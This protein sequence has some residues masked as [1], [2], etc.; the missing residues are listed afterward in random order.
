MSVL[1]GLVLPCYGQLRYGGVANGQDRG[2]WSVKH[3]RGQMRWSRPR[4]GLIANRGVIMFSW[5]NWT[6]IFPGKMGLSW[7]R[8]SW[9]GAG[10]R[11]AAEAEAT[12]FC[13]VI[14]V[15]VQLCDHI[16]AIEIRAL[17][18]ERKLQE[19]GIRVDY[20]DAM[21]PTFVELG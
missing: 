20:N 2:V 9:C 17:V 6:C 16:K 15:P 13:N 7:K 12:K 14:A 21:V 5:G 11:E 1:A 18:A 3:S 8:A 19:L 4:C 10:T